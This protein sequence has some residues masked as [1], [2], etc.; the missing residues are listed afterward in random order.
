MS[1]QVVAEIGSNHCGDPKLALELVSMCAA[2]GANA[3]KLQKRTLAACL[4]PELLAEPYAG[5]H[6]YGRTYGEHRAALELPL[7]AHADLRDLA[8]DLGMEYG[9]TPFD[10][11]SLEEVVSLEPDFIKIASSHATELSFV[12]LALSS[13]RAVYV[14]TG[15]CGWDDVDRIYRQ[16]FDVAPGESVGDLTMLQCTA[17]YP[18]PPDMLDLGVIPQMLKRYPHARIGFSSHFNGISMPLAAVALGAEVVEVHVTK[19]RT[20]KGT[21]HSLSLEPQGL[22]RL[23][24]DIRRFEEARGDVKRVY[25]EELKALRRMRPSLMPG[26]KP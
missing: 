17:R 15:G 22:R 4:T 13:G 2:A 12:A 8:H 20:M 7:E 25:P 24:R 23:V 21:D 26:A 10:L 3:V 5:E 19:D 9:C 16:A 1:V 11:I 18:C 6:S 14:S